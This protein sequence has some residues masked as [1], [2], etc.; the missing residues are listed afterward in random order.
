M[1]KQMIGFDLGEKTLKMVQ[2]NGSTVKA[3]VCEDLPDNLVL[4]GRILSVDAM[5]DFI[6]ESAKAGGIAAGNVSMVLPASK[7]FVRN[8][9][10]PAV[11]DQQMKYN[12]G[13]IFKDYLT[14]P[15]A[16][17][18]FDYSVYEVIEN[19][20]A[21]P[22]MR[23]MACAVQ[24]S[25]IEEYR[26]VLKKAGFKLKCAVPQEVAIANL[27]AATGKKNQDSCVIDLG[28]RSTVL[29]MFHGTEPAAKSTLPRGGLTLDEIISA[30]EGVD[31]HM[32]C[33]YKTTN[34][35]RVLNSSRCMESFRSLSVEIMKAVNFFNYNHSGSGIQEIYLCGGGA[36][37]D[38]LRK[39]LQDA[40]GIP[41]M[42][43]SRLLKPNSQTKITGQL[44][45]A[46]GAAMNE[47]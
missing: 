39:E 7:V 35:N 15:Q 22:D 30:E 4:D 12:M 24:T 36:S 45:L 44:V 20:D 18:T 3:A 41:V 13:Y 28:H 9:S 11:D 32:A 33:A 47:V 38:P 6:K 21:T 29:N 2:M 40:A 42:D 10:M 34:Y 37:A 23:F 17:Y 5:A 26:S 43:A 31:M 16:E 1:S 46:C 27:L 19:K 14:K 8:L 25:F